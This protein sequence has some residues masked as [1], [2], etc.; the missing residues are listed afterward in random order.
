MVRIARWEGLT[1]S[2]SHRL[3][4]AE[5]TPTALANSSWLILNAMRMLL[6]RSLLTFFMAMSR[7]LLCDFRSESSYRSILLEP[8]IIGYRAATKAYEKNAKR[9]AYN[10]PAISKNPGEQR[11]STQS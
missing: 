7:P 11:Q 8:V 9:T 1:R 2:F 4:T 3:I 6:M 10:V 5:D